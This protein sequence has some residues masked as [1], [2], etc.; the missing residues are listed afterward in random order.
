MEHR[1]RN[2]K[3]KAKGLTKN[4]LP[5]GPWIY[6]HSDGKTVKAA[7]TY[8]DK[9]QFTGRW[10]WFD[11]QGMLRQ[12]GSFHEGKQHGRWRRYFA[13][14]DQLVDEGNY[15]LG[16]RVGPWTFYRKDGTVK[17]HKRFEP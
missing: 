2:G 16:K 11:A 4:G 14:T 7:G 13:G 17:S 6:Y 9:G 5:V 10:K 3:V 12:D 15:H 1:K 8:D